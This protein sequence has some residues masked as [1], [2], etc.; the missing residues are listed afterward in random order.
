MRDVGTKEYDYKMRLDEVL[1]LLDT[2]VQSLGGDGID[3]QD[4]VWDGEY[5]HFNEVR[6]KPKYTWVNE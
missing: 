3:C 4:W 2:Y 1:K 5:L 6:I